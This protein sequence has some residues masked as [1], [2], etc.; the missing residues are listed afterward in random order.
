MASRNL[1]KKSFRG[2]T[3]PMKRFD[4]PETQNLNSEVIKTINSFSDEIKT[5]SSFSA[6][7]PLTNVQENQ[8]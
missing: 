4:Y 7:H 6:D 8:K 1:A 3:A 2:P 5:I